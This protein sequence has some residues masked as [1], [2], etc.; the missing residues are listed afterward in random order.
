MKDKLKIQSQTKIYRL[1]N[2][3][4][5]KFGIFLETVYDYG[6]LTIDGASQ[7]IFLIFEASSAS[8]FNCNN[9]SLERISRNAK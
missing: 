3:P 5:H 2:E 8:D 1:L 4:K 9:S 7:I 6:L